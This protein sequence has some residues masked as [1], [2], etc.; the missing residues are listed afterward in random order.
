MRK[1]E[2]K[3]RAQ[4]LQGDVEHWTCMAGE[5]RRRE[6]TLRRDYALLEEARDRL[7]EDLAA[8]RREVRDLRRKPLQDTGGKPA[9]DMARLAACLHGRRSIEPAVTLTLSDGSTATMHGDG[10]VPESSYLAQYSRAWR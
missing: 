8:A 2:W 1:H 4:A 7:A 10:E 5:A 6:E 9:M 3:A